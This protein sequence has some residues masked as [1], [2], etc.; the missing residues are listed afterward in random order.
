MQ[1]HR[2]RLLLLATLLLAG[3]TFGA[4]RFNLSST[5]DVGERYMDM[6]LLGTVEIPDAPVNSIRVDEMSGLAWDEDEGLLYA[7]S[8]RGKL[9]H[10]KPEFDGNGRLVDVE[11]LAAF[12]LR[13]RYGRKLKKPYRDTEGLS[14]LKAANGKRGDSELLISFEREPKIARFDNHG[15]EIKALPL[16][17][18]LDDAD[19]YD[20]TNHGLESVTVHPRHG[21]I[22]APE[23]PLR[24]SDGITLYNLDGK[25][26]RIPA[27]PVADNAIVGMETMPDGD[28]L[29][30]ERAFSSML[31][32]IVVSLHR[33][34]LDDACRSDGGRKPAQSCA[35]RP[36]AI[37][38]SAKGWDLDNF[39]G[40]ARHRGNRY[41][42]VSDN[43]RFWLQRTLLSYFEVLPP[44]TATAEGRDTGKKP[45]SGIGKP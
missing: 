26:W 24:G 18:P 25:Q 11:V 4:D 36:V 29:L 37:M 19:R 33:V 31:S 20:T 8:N 41:F 30:L 6:R 12:R 13:T 10:L 34:R 7:L 9:F 1:R 22:T 3:A 45:E 2:F 38:S 35:S 16:P 21:I 17:P 40:L 44:E 27:F 42:M 5:H 39:E 28:L 15:Y 43:N 14:L 32:P 23:V